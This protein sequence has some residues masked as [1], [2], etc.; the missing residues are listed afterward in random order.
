MEIVKGYKTEL[1]LNNKQITACFNHS[2]SA[3]FTW[4]WGLDR[5]KTAY[6]RDGEKLNA[7][8]LHKELNELKKT[9]F[10][11]LYQVSKCAPQEALRNLDKAFSNFFSKRAKYPKFKSRK[12]GIGSFTFTGTVKVFNNMIQL[13]RLGKLG[14]KEKGYLPIDKHI[15]KATVSEKAGRW[16]VSVQVKEDIKVPKNNGGIAGTDLGIKT[17][18]YVSDGKK[19]ENPK[20]LKRFERKLSRA[21]RRLSKRRK[22]SKNR[23]KQK[24]IVQK[25]HRKVKNIRN[26]NTHKV[27]SYLAKNKSFNC[28]ENLSVKGMLKNRRLSKALSDAGLGEFGRQMKYKCNWYGSD[29]TVADRWFPSTKRCSGCGS[30]KDMPLSCRIYCCEEC[31]LVIDRDYNA[32]LNLRYYMEREIGSFGFPSVIDFYDTSKSM[33]AVSLPETLNAFGEGSSG[34]FTEISETIF[35]ELGIEHY[36]GID[37]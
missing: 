18:A 36:L 11:W 34:L 22:G 30:I 14:L 6:K 25:I 15:L 29:L 32:S 4:N 35:D 3:R 31:G 2:G 21:Q 16:F 28:I 17:L 5:R 33:V 37:D 19:F 9:D 24:R 7:I 13:P 8:A 12:K 10:D 26:D 27:T 20:A 1:K 23:L